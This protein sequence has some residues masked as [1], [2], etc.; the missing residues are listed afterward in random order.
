MQATVQSS[1]QTSG[2][3]AEMKHKS[4]STGSLANF[5]NFPPPEACMEQVEDTHVTK[6]GGNPASSQPSQVEE[7]AGN[8]PARNTV[9][10]LLFELSCPVQTPSNNHS[11]VSAIEEAKESPS[12]QQPQQ[13]SIVPIL[14][15]ATAS[16]QQPNS[17]VPLLDGVTPRIHQHSVVSVL[18]GSTSGPQTSC[19]DVVTYNQVRKINILD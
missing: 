14:D 10:Y 5:A 9:E 18:D 8:T 15:V 17:S 13:H 1:N 12:P 16:T 7:I 3:N 6:N 19:S 2:N 4:V 11:G